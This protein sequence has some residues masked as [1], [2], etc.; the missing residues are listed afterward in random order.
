VADTAF[1]K[2]D[3]ALRRRRGLLPTGASP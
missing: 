1:T 3:L 2:A